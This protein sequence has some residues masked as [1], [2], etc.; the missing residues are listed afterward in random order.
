M[1]ITFY[2]TDSGGRLFYYCISDRQRHLFSRHAFTVS[3]GVALT[4]GREKTFTFDSREEKEA[5]LRQIITGRVN[6][7]YKVLYTYFRRNEYGELRA[8]LRPTGPH[9]SEAAS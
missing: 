2:R 8:A 3:W 1:M 7:G 9:G 6:A 4:K 5:K